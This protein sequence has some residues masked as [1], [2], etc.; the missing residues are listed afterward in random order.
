MFCCNL[1]YAVGDVATVTKAGHQKGQR[2]EVTDPDWNGLVKVRM[3]SGADEGQIKSYKQSQLQK[4]YGEAR[5]FSSW[6]SA[7]RR[8]RLMSR[9]STARRM[10]NPALNPAA[11]QPPAGRGGDFSTASADSKSNA[12]SSSSSSSNGG[13]SRTVNVLAH[14]A[15]HQHELDAL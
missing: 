13:G 10:T 2:A 8:V 6:R 12:G 4:C 7:G 15:M 14:P 11:R 5:R 1:R 3:L 9:V